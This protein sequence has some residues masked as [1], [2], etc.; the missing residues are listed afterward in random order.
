M[1]LYETVVVVRQEARAEGVASLAKIYTEIL[2]KAG[3]KVPR[4]ESWGLRTLAFPIRKNL[5]AHY[6]MLCVEA[7]HSAIAEME[8]RLR[9]DDKVLRY[10]TVR[11]KEHNTEDSPMVPKRTP[12]GD[13]RNPRRRTEKEGAPETTL[14]ESRED[15]SEA[16]GASDADS[17]SAA[18]E[19]EA[20]LEKEQA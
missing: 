13:E 4:W 16:S 17:E 20:M 2:E 8:S 12:E 14:E 5:K 1:T 9:Y 19:P 10:M 3:G 15:N 6:F 11:V 18:S 7:P